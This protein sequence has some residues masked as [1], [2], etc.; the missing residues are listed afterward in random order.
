MVYYLVQN[1]EDTKKWEAEFGWDKNMTVEKM[2]KVVIPKLLEEWKADDLYKEERR[3][4]PVIHNSP[5][6]YGL[7]KEE[8]YK[9]KLRYLKTKRKPIA[10]RVEK[11]SRK[12]M[13]SIGTH[14][15]FYLDLWGEAKDKLDRL[16]YNIDYLK[17]LISG[18]VKA[19]KTYN[20]ESLKKVP[21]DKII[22][23]NS[24]GF[25]KL[26]NEKTPSCKWYKET[27]RWH[28]FGSDEGGDV[29]DLVSKIND[30]SF[31]EAC[32]ILSF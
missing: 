24:A 28:D 13:L 32:K 27:N 18:R 7:T 2:S 30:C 17:G 19:G 16:D 25:F 29:I 21:I 3:N 8:V 1:E 15:D 6:D 26:R 9:I 14:K 12:A 4:N 11:F 22:E 10:L 31:R 5:E 23:V 20:V